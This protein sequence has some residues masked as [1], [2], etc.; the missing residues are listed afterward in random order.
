MNDFINF[1]KAESIEFEENVD[2]KRLCSF[3]VGGNVRVVAKPQTADQL[4]ALY[5]FLLEND[6]RNIL[7][8]RGSN[9]VI[10]DEGFD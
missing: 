4:S 2:G 10:S 9:V 6:I 8:G 1:L 3:H 5:D 7:L